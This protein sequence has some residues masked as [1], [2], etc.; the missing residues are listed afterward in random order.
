MPS[1]T[2]FIVDDDPAV[3]ESV[4]A[5][6]EIRG[7]R[8]NA[9]PSAEAFLKG[10]DPLEPG[11]LVTDIRM[12][13]GMSGIQLQAALRQRGCEIPVIVISAFA[14]VSNAVQAMAEGAV[15]LL[16]K[17][18]SSD[19]LWKAISEGLERDRVNREKRRGQAELLARFRDLTPEEVHVMERIV[20]GAL[21]KVIA[22][23]M[24]LSLRTVEARRASV[25]KKVGANSVP[26]LVRQY[27]ELENVYGR[28]P[29][30]LLLGTG[31]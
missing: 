14:N 12:E 20:E 24:G 10:F 26:E 9:F 13:P 16:E 3:R 5:L 11:C 17:G 4:A 28:R 25:L 15:T 1:G 18:C 2:V 19:Q 31:P 23:D 29:A 30:E 6:A 21:N 27:V 8:V 7:V 22:R